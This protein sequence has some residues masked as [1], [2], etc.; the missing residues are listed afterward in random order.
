MV[1][2]AAVP[3]AS[4]EP[5]LRGIAGAGRS[6]GAVVRSFALYVR[7]LIAAMPRRVLLALILTFLGAIT[8][9]V[10]L[11][12]L[13]PLLGLIGV[14][15]QQGSVGR[16]AEWTAEAFGWLGLPLNLFSVLGIYVALIAGD[17]R[18]RRWQTVTYCSLQAGFTAHLRK[19]V[20]RVVTRARWVQLIRFSTADLTNAMTGQVERVGN[21]VHLVLGLARNMTLAA[22]YLT[23]TLYVSPRVT[24]LV[25]SAGLVLMLL[26][27]RQAR[28]ATR[29]GQE[30]TRGGAAAYRAVME[31][32]GSIKMAKTYG[33]G[34]RSIRLF[35]ELADTVAAT[36]LQ[37]ATAQADSKARFDV[38]GA[39][40]LG[41]VLYVTIG[42][43]H[44]PPAVILVLVVA[45]ARVMP[46]VS[47]FAQ[48]MQHLLSMLSDCDAVLGLE[49]RLAPYEE[50]VPVRHGPVQLK[51]AVRLDTVAF[52]YGDGAAPA[53]M[54]LSLTIPA[55]QTTAIVGTSG[56][57][58]STLADLLLGLV[59]PEIGRVLVDG[60][61]LTPDLLA[62]WRD[63][64]GYVP[65]DG[66]H[67]HDTVR[68]NL[69]WARPE[70]S[71]AELHEALE[72]AAAGF[73]ASLP[74]GIDT[75]L[76]D[77]GIRL[78][79]G[80]RQ[81]I[82]LARALVRRPAMLI[83]D[84]ATSNLDSENE[85]R[86]QEAIERLHGR[87]TIVVITHR[88]TTVRFADLIH[89]LD[90]GRLVESGDWHSLLNESA[91]RFRAMCVAQGLPV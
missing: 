47:S 21:A 29:L 18:I 22:L 82:A 35:A 25:V 78:S 6:G 69:L 53:L 26:L 45:F 39:L 43:L 74:Q 24:A 16:V 13:V 1:V 75:V 2:R 4:V 61:P 54:S 89:V 84:E 56:S 71:E 23:A 19:R 81:R 87:L 68:A 17:A 52:H 28:A 88:L 73:V 63:Q 60:T 64:I 3:T 37:A 46:L 12:V 90:A 55:G 85:R 34:E 32:L 59:T 86:V 70:A 51:Q 20:H 33:V 9:G 72:V 67:F 36:N 76:G 14:D 77:R 50:A 42:V 49:A 91:G 40:V 38:G 58:K 27:G 44:T 7:T 11:L 66:F 79:G 10:G 48:A 83:L 31:H 5:S 65:Q 30:I 15:V 57:G 41:L 62:A 8:E 80:E